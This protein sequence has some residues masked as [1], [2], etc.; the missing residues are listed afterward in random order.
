LTVDSLHLYS[1]VLPVWTAIYFNLYDPDNHINFNRSI[2]VQ[3]Y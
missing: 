3:I 2:P 1:G